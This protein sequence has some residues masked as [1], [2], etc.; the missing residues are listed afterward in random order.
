MTPFV[1]SR[2]ISTSIQRALLD[3]RTELV[4]RTKELSTGRRADPD[5]ALGWKAG[6]LAS[7]RSES[8]ALQS[9]SDSN[10]I[11]GL[12]LGT[13]DTEI[14]AMQHTAQDMLQALLASDGSRAN[15][16]A[17]RDTGS[18][19]LGSLISNLNTSLHGDFLFAGT[20]TGTKP[21][22]D[23]VE[24]GSPARLA[25]EE[26][27]VAAFGFPPSSVNVGGISGA[28][29]QAFL[30]NQF[31]GLFD[32][33]SWTLRWSSASDHTLSGRISPTETAQTSISGNDT[34]FRTLAQAYTMLADLGL[35]HMGA[36]TSNVVTRTAQR[37]LR[38]ALDGL[39]G[40]RATIGMVRSDITDATSRMSVQKGLIATQIDNLERVD[41]YEV[42]TRINE[43]QTTIEA[44]Y[45]LTA[46][47]GEL[48]LARYI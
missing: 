38:S 12:R 46:Q 30:D 7:L 17:V 39:T 28:D 45:R 25:V 8:S 19:A 26:A 37:L 22:A 1:S 10:Q 11:I 31:A 47:L 43:L 42:T 36:D 15:V 21:I 24:V 32:E 9:L 44:S 41:G 3:L 48:S 14:E 5:L 40:L 16:T 20:N 18:S 6:F 34:A 23:N 35:E 2:T 4:A 33:G 29:M 27:F 13:T